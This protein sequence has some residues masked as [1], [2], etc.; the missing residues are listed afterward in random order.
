[1]GDPMGDEEEG[2]NWLKF[3]SFFEAENDDWDPLRQ[4]WIGAVVS[5]PATGQQNQTGW[6][7]DDVGSLGRY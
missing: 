5:A 1:M 2:K 3:Y 4:G 7:K 6:W